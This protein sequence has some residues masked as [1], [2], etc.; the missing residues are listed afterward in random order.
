M[1]KFDFKTF[2]NEF[3]NK[4]DY[5]VEKKKFQINLIKKK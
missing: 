3:I 2:A 4:E 5:I 1:L